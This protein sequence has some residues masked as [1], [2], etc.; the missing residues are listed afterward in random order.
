MMNSLSFVVNSDWITLLFR[1]GAAMGQTPIPWLQ[2]VKSG[3]ANALPQ[4]QTSSQRE[5]AHSNKNNPLQNPL[6][7][8]K[9]ANPLSP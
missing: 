3:S 1:S 4:R 7:Q 2:H 5:V 8:D 9:A 6:H